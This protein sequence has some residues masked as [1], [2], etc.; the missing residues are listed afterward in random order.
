MTAPE[1]VVT[2]RGEILNESLLLVFCE[3]FGE[4]PASISRL[5]VINSGEWS[6]ERGERSIW[7]PR[8]FGTS[9][10]QSC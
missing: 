1:R 8:G 7:S 3:K 5:N 6:D 4:K 9:R 10:K 2:I